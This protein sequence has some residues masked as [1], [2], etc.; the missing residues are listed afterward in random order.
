MSL[1]LRLAIDK[2]F[3]AEDVAFL[4]RVIG[5]LLQVAVFV[6]CIAVK[7]ELDFS[8]HEE[9]NRQLQLASSVKN[10]AGVFNCTVCHRFKPVQE[11]CS[12]R[13]VDCVEQLKVAQIFEEN[14]GHLTLCISANVVVDPANIRLRLTLAAVG[15]EFFHQQG[16]L[17]VIHLKLFLDNT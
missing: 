10:L 17:L 9:I 4:A 12:G 15:L 3:Q 13:D 2:I 5:K 14:L 6:W 8:L 16:I 7:S 1:L 11:I